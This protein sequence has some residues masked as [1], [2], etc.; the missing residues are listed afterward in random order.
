MKSGSW[1]KEAVYISSRL[2]NISSMRSVTRKPPTTLIVP[3]AIAITSSS[4]LRKPSASPISSRPPSR[5]MPWI[6]LVA[7]ISGV[8]SVFGTFE[9][10]SKP[11]NAAS[12]RMVSSVRRSITRPPPSAAPSCTIS[13]SRVMQ[14][15]LM[16]SSSKSSSSS[17]SLTISS[18]SD[19][20]LRAYSDEAWSGIVD[21][22]LAGPTIVTSSLTTVWPG[23]VSSQLPPVS[24]AR[25]TITEPGF[26]FLTACSV[27]S[28]GARRPGHGGGRDDRVHLADLLGEQL[29]LLLLLLL[30]QLAGVAAGGLGVLEAHVEL[31]EAGA[32][33][34]DLLLDGRAHVEGLDDR[35]EAARGGDRLE[36]GHAGAE[37][38]HLG[39]ADGAGGGGEHREEAGQLLG[40]DQGGAVAGHRGL[41]GERV[42]RLGA[43]DAR[44]RLH[45]EARHARLGERADRVG[46]RQRREEADQ[47]RAARQPAD[48]L[49]GRRGDLGHH[50]ARVAVAERGA[51]LLVVGV[52]IVRRRRPRRPRP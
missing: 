23:S 8:C 48:L 37:H 4:L 41:R 49:G 5:T 26:M 52:R 27:T 1:R 34:L 32:E 44:D 20:T 50:L 16:I 9:I 24:A 29:A 38:E 33:R 31:E 22:R 51:G 15:P 40:G 6:A 42:H 3:K 11:T 7:D 2:L 14:A 28:S 35:A 21:A 43:R 17:P 10:T 19:W 46:R 13:P 12:T 36:A 18:S 30:G 39:G 25:S 47:H 45:R